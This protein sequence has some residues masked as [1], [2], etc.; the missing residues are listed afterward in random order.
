MTKRLWIAFI[1]LLTLVGA[2]VVIVNAQPEDP[3]VG[4][5]PGK[6]ASDPAPKAA[7]SGTWETGPGGEFINPDGQVVRLVGA[8][9]AM[10]EFGASDPFV[11]NYPIAGGGGARS[12]FNTVDFGKWGWNMARITLVSA[13][14]P[15][16]TSAQVQRAAALA[17]ECREAKIVCMFADFS[18]PVGANP[19]PGSLGS[20]DA[21]WQ[22]LCGVAGDNPY[23]WINYTNEPFSGG[24]PNPGWGSLADHAYNLIRGAGCTNT[25]L[26]ID[27]GVNGQGAPSTVSSGDWNAFAS[28]KHHVALS[29]H[30]YMAGETPETLENGRVQLNAAG[31]PWL[32]GEFA[33]QPNHPGSACCGAASW[34][35]QRAGALKVIQDWIPKGESALWWIATG[36]SSETAEH[37]LR[38]PDGTYQD[39]GTSEQGLS[40]AGSALWA[41]SH[42]S[43]VLGEA[44]AA[45]VTP[46]PT[47]TPPV[48]SPSPGHGPPANLDPAPATD[49]GPAIVVQFPTANARV[50][51]EFTAFGTS[52]TFE[53][54]HIVQVIRMAGATPIVLAEQV[55][56]ASCGTGCRGTW[57]AEMQLPS[58]A[59]GPAVF[60]AFF[61]SAEDGSPQNVIDIPIV[62]DPSLSG[63]TPPTTVTPPLTTPGGSM[64][65]LPPP[66]RRPAGTVP[67]GVPD[68]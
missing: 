30:I 21:L 47:V 24:H 4:D 55:V 58:A 43:H 13:A 10:Q 41:V 14:A 49:T 46:V 22:G 52:N 51:L 62:I 67:P 57:R 3:T 5:P 12:F 42:Q 63:V 28:G 19:P 39:N 33:Y 27:A 7:A 56:T 16:G 40:E 35:V 29:W 65:S 2:T 66:S 15:G 17:E 50:G 23:L 59:T 38:T 54:T 60:R 36:D 48:D 25:M 6:T 64:P 20:T 31:V 53:A 32:V 18:S 44:P 68:K 1:A 45:P 34:D 37:S 61:Y 11:F 9:A 26:V 8:N